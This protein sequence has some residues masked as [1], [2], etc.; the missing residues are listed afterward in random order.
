MISGAKSLESDVFLKVKKIVAAGAGVV[1]IVA[2][3]AHGL[4]ENS[5]LVNSPRSP[6]PRDG[7]TVPYAI[8][9]V[10][11]YITKSQQELLSWLIWIA[12]GSG[13]IACDSDTPRRSVQI[14]EVSHLLQVQ[15]SVARGVL[16]TTS[17]V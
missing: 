11:V 8:K 15:Q 13:M 12:I 14:K 5:I 1:L 7:M 10:T 2:W 17:T 6:N 16:R 4:L 3:F 9:R